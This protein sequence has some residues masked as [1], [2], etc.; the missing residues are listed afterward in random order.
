MAAAA[1]G[2]SQSGHLG[3]VAGEGTPQVH[4][5]VLIACMHA[6]VLTGSA[7]VLVA[8]TEAIAAFDDRPCFDCVLGQQQQQQ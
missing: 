3:A 7:Q 4:A 6:C 1:P 5:H 8:L 2:V